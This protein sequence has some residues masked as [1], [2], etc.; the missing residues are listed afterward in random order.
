MTGLVTTI[1]DKC[2]RCYSCIRNCPAKAIMV[3]DGQAKVIDERCVGC[4]NCVR[5]CAQSAKEVESGIEQ[6][7][8]LLADDGRPVFAALAPSFPAAFAE[9]RPRQVIA[10]VRALG[11]AEVLEVAFGAEL[12]AEA[13]ARLFQE[14]QHKT[15]IS[16]ACPAVVAYVEKHVPSLVPSL[17]PVVSPMAALGR[18]VKERYRPDARVVFIGPCIAKKAERGEEGVAGYIDAVLTFYELRQMLATEGIE[19]GTQPDDRFDGPRAGLGRIFPVSGG[20]LK[21]AALAADVLETDIVV[22]DGKDATV[23]MLRELADGKVDIRLLDVLFCQGCIG[24]PRV[25]NGLSLVARR[26][27][28]ADFVADLSPAEWEAAERAR[29][30]YATLDLSRSFHARPVANLAVPSEA[31]IERVLERT[32]KTRPEDHLNCGACGYTTCR[33]KAIAVCQGL[34]EAEMCLP[35]LIE[36]LQANCSDLERMHHELQEAQ[37]Q[38][39]QSEK[40]ASM[41]QLAAGVAHEV[42]NPLGTILLCAHMLLRGHGAEAERMHAIRM[43]IDEATRCRTIVSGLLN[44]ARQGK[45]SLREVQL[46]EVLCEVVTLVERQPQFAAVEIRLALDSALPQIEADPSQLKDVFIN[47]VVNAAEAMPDGGTLTIATR[48]DGEATVEA[49]FADT[50]CGIPE[51]N[52]EKIFNPFFTT[53]QIGQGT[54]LGLAISYGIV[55]MHKGQI[56]VTSKVGEGTTFTV[57]LPIKQSAGS[58]QWALAS[59]G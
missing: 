58:Q 3:E 45:L 8:A 13:Y 12:V 52:L 9:V 10:A 43:M 57:G 59:L 18:A 20:L 50:G 14:A 51:A 24:G 1:K 53:K 40:L 39:I 5:V 6:V 4:G 42:N 35:Y 48:W 30:E 17:A 33:E 23:E 47:V 19:M 27:I 25:Q 22:A 15:L 36:Q 46:N 32:N 37:A 26:K 54:G 38:L 29:A 28:V 31:Q 49:S 21:T 41:G 55:K 56:N 11:F 16:T 34:A 44:F 2:R 7:A